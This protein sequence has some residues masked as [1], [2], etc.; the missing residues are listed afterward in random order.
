MMLLENMVT[1]CA[2][3]VLHVLVA[4]SAN[5]ADTRISKQ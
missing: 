2:D 1:Q 3:T 4:G 5:S